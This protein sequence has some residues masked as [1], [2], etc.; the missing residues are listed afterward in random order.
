MREARGGSIC[1]SEEP[2]IPM[3]ARRVML[4]LGLSE[5]AWGVPDPGTAP[6]GAGGLL[7]ARHAVCMQQFQLQ[8]NKA[9]PRPPEAASFSSQPELCSLQLGPG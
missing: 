4:Q 1:R 9:R 3:R 2:R 6:C 8:Y 5:W 7:R